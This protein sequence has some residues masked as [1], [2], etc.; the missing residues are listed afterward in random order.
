MSNITYSEVAFVDSAIPDLD[1]FLS[2][3]RPEVNAIVIDRSRPGL[4]QIALALKHCSDLDAVHIVAHGRPGEVYLGSDVISLDTISKHGSELKLIG[5]SVEGQL[6]LWSC[7]AGSGDLGAAFAAA[8]MQATGVRVLAATGL[9]GAE[10]LGGQWLLDVGSSGAAAAPAPLTPEGL[11]AYSGL[12]KWGVTWNPAGKEATEGSAIALGSISST[13]GTAKS[14]VISGVPVGA[15]LTDGQGHSFTASAGQTAVDV[16]AWN[17]SQLTITPAND[18]DFVLTVTANHASGATATATELVIVDPIAPTVKVAPASG[19]EG[20]AIAVNVAVTVNALTGDSNVLS[21]LVISNIP[22]GAVLSDGHGHSFTSTTSNSQI[23]IHAWNYTT[24]TIT[25]PNDTNFTLGIAA[26]AADADGNTS[27][28]TN[29]TAAVTVNP[30]AP[31]VSWSP[32][33]EIGVEGSSIKLGTISATVGRLTGDSNSLA[34]LVVSAIPV[35]A[36]LSDGSGHSFT[37]SAGH[38]AIDVLGWSLANLM[39]TPSTDTNFTLAV[40]A[41]ERDAEGNLGT[42]VSATEAVTVNPLAPTV[43]WSPS[44]EIGVEGSSIKLGTISATVGG[45]TGDSNSLASLVVSAIPVGA[46]LSDGSGH[47]FTASA[48][49]TAIDVLGWSLANLMITPSTDINFTLTVTATERDAEGNLGAPASATEAVTVNPLAATASWSPSAEIGVEG[50]SI[51]LGTISATVGGLTGDSNSLASLVVSAIPV[52]ATLSDGSGHSFT[53]SAGHTSIDVLGWSLANLAITPSTDT[54]FTLTVTATERDAEGNLAAPVSATEAVTVNPPQSSFTSIDLPGEWFIYAQAINDS[55][56]V[57]GYYE[58]NTGAHGFLYNSGIY[59]TLDDPLAIQGTN[60]VAINGIGQIA[61]YYYDNNGLPHG[62]VYSA[63]TYATIDDPLGTYGTTV[64]GITSTGEV[65]GNYFDNSGEHGFIYNAGTFI[66]LNDPLAV[67]GT[68]VQAA[69]GSGQVVGFYNDDIGSGQHGFIYNAGQYTTVDD[70][71]GTNGTYLQAINDSGKAV[72]NYYDNSGEHG[73]IYNAGTYTT[74]DDP[75]ATQGTSVQ[76]ITASGEIVGNY[77]DSTGEHGFTYSAGTYTTIDDPAA[78]AGTALTAINDGGQVAGGYYT[79]SFDSFLYA[80]GTFINLQDPAATTQTYATAINDNGQVAG[81]EVNNTG[82]HG[83]L[84]S[85]GTYITLDDP[86]AVGTTDAAGINSS[87]EIAGY[88]YGSDSL[89]HGFVYSA[90]TYTTVD[91]PLATHGTYL[92]AINDSG[93]TVGNYFDN[94]GEHGFVYNSGTYFTLDAP[95]ATGTTNA[96]GIN[97][98]GDVV[99][100]YY[101]NTA[102]HGFIYAAGT[103]IT[104][105]DPLA[106]HGTYAQAIND[107][108]E[109]IGYYTD[110]SGQHGFIYNGSTYSTLD[111]PM[112]NGGDTHPMAINGSGQIVGYYTDNSGQHGFLYSN[113]T[114]TT[115][116][117][118]STTQEFT[119]ITAINNSGEMTGYYEPVSTHGFAT[120]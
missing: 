4:G 42:P 12:L 11:A 111:D 75:A 119:G 113:G 71:L 61:G 39:I 74:L 38:T 31:A 60:A 62:F 59:T 92:Q 69:N 101:D 20:V 46:T 89:P 118:P 94:S 96:V 15:V 108:G 72:G 102:A 68:T 64:Q 81:N 88:Y 7:E 29:A 48:G 22:V 90:N 18:V 23:D 2:A 100:Y 65:I 16:S 53:A 30:L 27:T 56:Q 55:G 98:S 95:Q 3:I 57:V 32:S 43:S 91:D 110:N 109:V 19:V 106:T 44:A 41:T 105:D 33:A 10:V 14:L 85:S 87:G 80:S 36:T 45:L 13:G 17:L 67:Y 107:N 99:G 28:T 26:T 70:P 1:G 25:A 120:V 52:G 83:F 84:Y 58:N 77:F 37:S 9:V 116:V 115:I 104:L 76:G 97:G 5:Q 66:T 78:T 93:E 51:K 82:Q 50:S 79:A 117:D 103:Y 8:L 49:H 47:S 54:N 35:G 112:A 21:G 34:S 63:A 24:L 40:T 73:F 6:L 86:Q 114:Y